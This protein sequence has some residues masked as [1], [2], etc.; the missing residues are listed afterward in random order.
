MTSATIK[1]GPAVKPVAPGKP[2]LVVAGP[3]AS[4]KSA[5]AMDLAQAFDGVIINA[6][7]MQVYKELR[8][9]TARPSAADEDRVTHRLYGIMPASEPCSVAHWREMAVQQ[10]TEAHAVGRVPVVTGGTGMYI[11]ALMQGLAAI[12]TVPPAVR[13]AVQVLYDEEGGG[14]AL[15]AL[16]DV[17]AETA[18]RLAPG[19]RQRVIRA[20]EVHRATGQSLSHWLAAGNQ[21]TLDDVSFQAVVLHPPRDT[22]YRKIDD[23]F[24]EMLKQGGMQEV[25][26]LLAKELDPALPAMKAVGVRELAAYFAGETSRDDA[27][28]GAQQASRNYAKRQSTWFRNQIPEGKSIFAQYSESQKEEIFSF[29][30]QF[31]LTHPF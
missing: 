14:A 22:L 23:R 10:V 28:A 20:L 21:G 2:V 17:D 8:V 27:V 11:R 6:D 31:V 16:A 7:S 26:A 25:E 13:Q 30:R 15:Q 5:L 1:T 19:D 12:P 9:L 24:V 18:S 29:V 4:G 3:T